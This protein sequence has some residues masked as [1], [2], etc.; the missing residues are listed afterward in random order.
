MSTDPLLPKPTVFPGVSIIP[1][2]YWLLPSFDFDTIVYCNG[3]AGIDL[4]VPGIFIILPDKLDCDKSVFQVALKHP[5]E[6]I[7][8]VRVFT[9]HCTKIFQRGDDFSLHVNGSPIPHGLNDCDL[10]VTSPDPR[11]KVACVSLELDSESQF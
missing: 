7:H 2:K 4:T 10:I 6:R 1:N 8:R 5:D 9:W 11:L 3:R